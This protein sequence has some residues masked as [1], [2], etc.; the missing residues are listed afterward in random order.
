MGGTTVSFTATDA[1]EK[2]SQTPGTVQVLYDFGGFGPPLRMNGSASIKQNKSGRT[3]P[4]KFQLLCGGVAAGDAVATISVFK[5]LS[6]A[7]GAV[8]ITDLTSDSGQAN[9]DGNQFRFDPIGQQYIFNLS[10]KG[11]EAPATYPYLRGSG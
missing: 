6:T 7:T 4:V 9:D 3:I 11:F 8:D 1:A 5:L 10:T 2:F